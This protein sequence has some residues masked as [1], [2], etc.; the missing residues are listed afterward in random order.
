LQLQ[1]K[2]RADGDQS[3]EISA[4]R[5]KLTAEQSAKNRLAADYE[6]LQR[7]YDELS[8]LKKQ[9]YAFLL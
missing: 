4:L 9:D 6:D 2:E 7:R 3:E 1:Y 8:R 5:R